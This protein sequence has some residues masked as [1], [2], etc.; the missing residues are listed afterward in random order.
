VDI[1]FTKTN[2]DREQVR[3]IQEQLFAKYAQI[4]RYQISDIQLQPSAGGTASV[5]FRKSWDFR[6]R[7][8]FFGSERE[9]LV[10]KHAGSGWKISSE[11]E[12]QILHAIHR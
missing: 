1:Y 7:H 3:L 5:I 6:G 2:V 8:T 9:R 10:L 12:L 4:V 11:Q